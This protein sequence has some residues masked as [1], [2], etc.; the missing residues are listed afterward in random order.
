MPDNAIISIES[1]P[2]TALETAK[3][4]FERERLTRRQA[5][6][7]FGMTAGM[8]AFAMFSVDDLAHIVGSAMKQR[9]GD[10]KVAAQ[11]AQEFQQ[12][13]VAFADPSGTP[14]SHCLA[15][16]GVDT[17]N[18][19]SAR[20]VCL[21]NGSTMDYCNKTIVCPGVNNATYNYNG[22]CAAHCPPGT[23]TSPPKPYYC[24]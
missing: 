9:A 17:Q 15:Q 4:K 3:E 18:V 13:G 23:C 5:L 6:K 10:N 8:A 21:L 11:I 19:I 7:R 14:C 16:Y 20:D 1:A 2:E 12:A 22:C 24:L